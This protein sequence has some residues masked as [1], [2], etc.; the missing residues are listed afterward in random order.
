MTV[1]GESALLFPDFHDCHEIQD[2]DDKLSKKCTSHCSDLFRLKV[3][4]K[5]SLKNS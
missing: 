1:I 2:F 5:K 4:V 3:T